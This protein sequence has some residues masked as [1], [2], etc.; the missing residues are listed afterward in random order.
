MFEELDDLT[1]GNGQSPE[2]S[3]KARIYRRMSGAKC[4][5]RCDLSKDPEYQRLNN[6]FHG[7]TT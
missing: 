3:C 7:V 6:Y 5:A 1:M 4:G 2:E